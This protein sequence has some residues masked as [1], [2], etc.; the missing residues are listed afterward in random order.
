M[1]TEYHRMTSHNGRSGYKVPYHHTY[2]MK[3]YFSVDSV[4]FVANFL[5]HPCLQPYSISIGINKAFTDG[6]KNDA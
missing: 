6:P 1:L 2:L 4:D 5:C 3:C